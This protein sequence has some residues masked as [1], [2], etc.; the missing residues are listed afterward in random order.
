MVLNEKKEET[1]EELEKV[2]DEELEELNRQISILNVYMMLGVK[3]T[4]LNRAE[5]GGTVP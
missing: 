4:Y 1:D 3:S 2:V 5:Q